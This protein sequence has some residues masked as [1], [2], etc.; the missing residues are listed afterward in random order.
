MI[1]ESHL[2]ALQYLLN[3]GDIQM[4]LTEI[5]TYVERLHGRHGQLE[6]D[7]RTISAQ[8]KL[9]SRRLRDTEKAR[10]IVHQIA[11]K[12]QEQLQFH[13]SDITSLALDAVFDEPYKL[14]V[15][16]IQRRNK[17]ECDLYFSRDGFRTDPITASG[18]GAIDVAAFALRIASWSM[19]NPK[20]QNV[21][22]LD[23]PFKH[24]KG[25]DANL[26]VLQVVKMLS[27]KLGIQFIIVS[28]ERIPREDIINNA[29]RVFEV[30]IK[31]K[32]TKI[33]TI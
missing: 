25:A 27:K 19:L 5:R 9:D 21:I 14:E 24:L 11:L 12:M 22:I 13:I 17:T 20:S 10:E 16:F 31:K 15:E 4:T 18:G 32:I 1:R 30:S 29:D 26:R 6:E 2:L 7:L 3:I 33:K 8:I 28:D 23:E